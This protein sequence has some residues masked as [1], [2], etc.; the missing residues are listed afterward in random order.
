MKEIFLS[1]LNMS[2]AASWVVL[3]V[4]LLRI[5]LKDAPKWVSCLLWGIVALRLVMPSAMESS[6]SLIPSAQ[7]FPKDI[8]TS[9]TPA[10]HSGIPAV[11]SAVNPVF[12]TRLCAGGRTGSTVKC[13]VG[14][15]GMRYGDR[16][17][18]RCGG[19]YPAAAAGAH[20]Y[21]V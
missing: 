17:A 6:F 8:L 3:A 12:T 9:Q 16:A 11:N 4:L 1:L 20:P 19:I 14:G 5:F 13:G 15:V 21:A 2:V 18:M 10:I 7:V